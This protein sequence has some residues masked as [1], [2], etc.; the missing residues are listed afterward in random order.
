MNDNKPLT[1][2]RKRAQIASANKQMFAWVAIAAVVVVVCAVL[3][4]NFV[5]RITYQAEVNGELNK[6]AQTLSGNIDTIDSLKKEVDKLNTD[7]NLN[8]PNLRSDDSTAFQVVL[9]ALPTEDDRVSLGSSLQQRILA[10]SGISIEQISVT[11][12]GSVGVDASEVDEAGEGASI[13]NPEAQAITFS[14]VI[15]GNYDNIQN[16]LRDI[17]RTI[18]PITIDSLNLQGT[19]EA[20][21]ATV[22]AT[23]Y[24]VPK[25]DWRT[26]EKTILTNDGKA[27][28]ETDETDADAQTGGE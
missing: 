15:H 8:L 23:T 6:T 24:Y 16:A 11:G 19:D 5:Q 1:G 27:S 2:V 25:V 28:D 7:K 12:V 20:L 13:V 22:N 18:R 21:Q 9:D 26:G 3:M 17:E 10:P 14:F 4:F